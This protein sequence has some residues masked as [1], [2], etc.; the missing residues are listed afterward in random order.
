MAVGQK[1][2]IIY[3]IG[4]YGV[5]DDFSISLKLVSELKKEKQL[6]AAKNLQRWKDNM[7]PILAEIRVLPPIIATFYGGVEYLDAMEEFY[8]YSQR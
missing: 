8:S 5:C 1:Q 7:K 2:T 3:D 4:D 6:D